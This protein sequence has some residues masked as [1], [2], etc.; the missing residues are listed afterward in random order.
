[1][2]FLR[3]GF[4]A[5]QDIFPRKSLLL[6]GPNSQDIIKLYLKTQMLSKFIRRFSSTKSSDFFWTDISE[7]VRTAEYAVRGLVPTTAT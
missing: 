4:P 3:E 1:M 5:S 2:A 7:G 6:L